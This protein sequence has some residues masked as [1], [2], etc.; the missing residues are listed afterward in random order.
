MHALPHLLHTF[1]AVQWVKLCIG[2]SA[3]RFCQ[4][5]ITLLAIH[6]QSLTKHLSAAMTAVVSKQ[7]LCV[8]EPYQLFTSKH[9]LL[10]TRQAKPG[11]CG[12]PNTHRLQLNQI[13][14]QQRRQQQ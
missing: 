8:H 6:N 7:E 11:Q 3:R 9:T 14:P 5:C 10:H 13:H 2:D 1:V 12:L 4:A